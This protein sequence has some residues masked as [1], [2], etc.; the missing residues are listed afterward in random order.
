MADQKKCKVVVTYVAPGQQLQVGAA[1]LHG[2]PG[3]LQLG[4]AA[5]KCSTWG[6]P[7]AGRPGRQYAQCVST[8]PLIQD[9]CRLFGRQLML[10]PACTLSAS[11]FSLMPAMSRISLHRCLASVSLK[12]SWPL[13]TKHLCCLQESMHISLPHTA[14][15]SPALEGASIQDLQSFAAKHCLDFVA[16]AFMQ[17]AEDVQY[18]RRTLATNEPAGGSIGIIARIENAAGL[19]KIDEVSADP[20]FLKRLVPWDGAVP[21][22]GS[23]LAS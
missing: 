20:A 17:S 2:T 18:V 21:C 10:M 23:S 19:S 22:W 12:Q 4:G 3:L 13:F 9:V 8:L 5:C 7:L 15:P 1:S 6:R 11:H 16:P 14:I